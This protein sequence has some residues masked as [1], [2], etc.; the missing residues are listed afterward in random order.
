MNTINNHIAAS[1]IYAFLKPRKQTMNYYSGFRFKFPDPEVISD[2]Q[3]MQVEGSLGEFIA[4]LETALKTCD[5]KTVYYFLVL[6][7]RR[8]PYL[9][10]SLTSKTCD[11]VHVAAHWLLP[12]R[13]YVCKTLI[14]L[15]R[16]VDATIYRAQ[17]VDELVFLSRCLPNSIFSYLLIQL[18]YEENR[19]VFQRP[20]ES[21]HLPEDSGFL[22]AFHSYATIRP[23][24]ELVARSVFRPM[25]TRKV[26]HTT[27]H[28]YRADAGDSIAN[29]VTKKSRLTAE[30]IIESVASAVQ[31][32]FLPPFFLNHVQLLLTNVPGE[33]TLWQYE[34]LGQ[35]MK[36]HVELQSN[37][38]LLFEGGV[39]LATLGMPLYVT[40]WIMEWL[41]SDEDI[42]HIKKIR[43]LESIYAAV[44]ARSAANTRNDLQLIPYEAPELMLLRFAPHTLLLKQH[45]ES[46][47]NQSPLL[48]HRF[49]YCPES[50]MQMYPPWQQPVPRYRMEEDK[51]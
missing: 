37:Y 31:Q 19:E 16:T 47:R 46:I 27:K 1:D 39:I 23:S 44:K 5:F 51:N 21:R 28:R 35:S 34:T 45:M 6:C 48:S 13:E 3:I 38:C 2:E 30:E 7:F 12:Q 24:F 25:Q 11:A 33:L 50:N 15:F 8:H 14:Y 22:L 41:I 36:S 4:T 29:P 9:K 10:A 18:H 20:W 42:P 32:G 43:R 17:I 26:I 40:C 49:L